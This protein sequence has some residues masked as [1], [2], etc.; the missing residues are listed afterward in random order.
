MIQINV[1]E[2]HDKSTY[3]IVI[4]I[5]DRKMEIVFDNYYG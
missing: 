2:I 4:V 3:R 1:L 5:L